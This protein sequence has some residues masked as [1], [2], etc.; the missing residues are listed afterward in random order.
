MIQA[1]EV[2]RASKG[3]FK[4]LCLENSIQAEHPQILPQ[5]AIAYRI[6]ESGV[7]DQAVRINGSVL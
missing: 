4:Q 1:V 5:M 7:E 6:P 2:G 3:F